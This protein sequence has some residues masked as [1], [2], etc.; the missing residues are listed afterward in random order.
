MKV[1]GWTGNGGEKETFIKLFRERRRMLDI[2]EY[3]PFSPLVIG[4]VVIVV[5]I[6][7][8]SIYK[9]N[10]EH[11]KTLVMIFLLLVGLYFAAQ[12]F[13]PGAFHSLI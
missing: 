6:F 9:V 8:Y 4:G 3:L 1:G 11:I 7:L 10:K 2:R 5:G 13:L 12:Y